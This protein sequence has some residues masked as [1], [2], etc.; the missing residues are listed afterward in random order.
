MTANNIK[1]F[2]D[3]TATMWAKM[4]EALSNISMPLAAHQQVQHVIVL[5]EKEFGAR[6]DA[7]KLTPTPDAP[8]TTNDGH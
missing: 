6:K 3:F 5:F 4:R 8:S 7:A 1:T 2:E